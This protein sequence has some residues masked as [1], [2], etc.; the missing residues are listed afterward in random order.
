MWTLIKQ[1]LML[2]L[3]TSFLSACTSYK[4][5]WDFAE[6]YDFAA[7]KK[8]QATPGMPSVRR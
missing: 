7:L 6:D 4:V 3:L 5:R 8:V 1:A 2:M